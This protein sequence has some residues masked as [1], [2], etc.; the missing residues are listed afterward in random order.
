MKCISFVIAFFVFANS[1]HASAQC[2]FIKDND[3]KNYCRAIS[4]KMPT[5]CEFI[6]DNSLKIEC[7]ILSKKDRK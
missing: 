4:K 6:R 3:R 1:A 7:R 5:W 2:E